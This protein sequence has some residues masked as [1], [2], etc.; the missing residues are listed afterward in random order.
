[1]KEDIENLKNKVYQR[2]YSIYKRMLSYCLK[3]RK[4]TES[5]NPNVARENNGRII[6]L[7]KCAVCGRQKS[8]FIEE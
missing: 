5:K 4:Y 1:M 2:F 6:I 8:K 7:S 3:C